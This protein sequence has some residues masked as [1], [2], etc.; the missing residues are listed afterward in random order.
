MCNT[1]LLE[2]DVGSESIY[3]LDELAGRALGDAAHIVGAVDS[4]RSPRG[5]DDPYIRDREHP[6]NLVL[7]CGAHH[8]QVDGELGQELF[9]VDVLREMKRLHELRIAHATA[10]AGEDRTVPVRLLGA[11]EGGSVTA[12]VNDCARAILHAEARLPG[13]PDGR[14]DRYGVDIDLRGFPGTGRDYYAVCARKIDEEVTRFKAQH[15]VGRLNRISLFAAAKVPILVYLGHALDDA[16]TVSIYQRHKVEQTWQ[17]PRLDTHPAF[18]IDTPDLD[19]STELVVL[20]GVTATPDLSALPAVV[21]Q[22]PRWS[23]TAVQVGDGVIDSPQALADFERAVRELYTKVDDATV[24]RVHLVAAVPVSAA[25]TIGR[26]LP[27]SHH[28]PVSLYERVPGGY[29]DVL[30]VTT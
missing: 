3:S 22:L 21:T 12:G 28:V 18:T 26:V 23:L 9:S 30:E 4:S 27:R 5:Q 24:T 19:G 13:W 2:G 7:A 1:D 8:R 25:V 20:I 17:W 29:V 16:I 14:H 6:D 11:I 10:L 15:E